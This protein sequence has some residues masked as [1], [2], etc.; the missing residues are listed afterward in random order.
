[1]GFHCL[2]QSK[3]G[4]LLLLMPSLHLTMLLLEHLG[5]V[6][7]NVGGSRGRHNN[8]ETRAKNFLFG[9]C[10][11]NLGTITEFSDKSN[12]TSNKLNRT[13]KAQSLGGNTVIYKS[14]CLKTMSLWWNHLRTIQACLPQQPPFLQHVSW[15]CCNPPDI[16]SYMV[17][18]LLFNSVFHDGVAPVSASTLKPPLGAIGILPLKPQTSPIILVCI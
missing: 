18:I 1:M 13:L 15:Q 2:L 3:E 7:W 10:I 14:I 17:E 11:V 8:T 16:P 5:V 4:L 12:R 9:L 6:L